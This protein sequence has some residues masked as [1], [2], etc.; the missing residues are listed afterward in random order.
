MTPDNAAN[1]PTGRQVTGIHIGTDYSFAGSVMKFRLQA[2]NTECAGL[3]AR[4]IVGVIDALGEWIADHEPMPDEAAIRVLDAAPGLAPQ[5]WDVTGKMAT[6]F[7]HLFT[8]AAALVLMYQEDEEEKGFV[9]SPAVIG[10]L[11]GVLAPHRQ[12]FL[13][14]SLR[15]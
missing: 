13:E 1:L 12:R 6:P 4:D 8:D 3:L 10:V 2:G 15:H 11:W 5:D 14:K 7:L 9:L